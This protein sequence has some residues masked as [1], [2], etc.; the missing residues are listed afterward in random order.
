MAGAPEHFD[1]VVVGTGFGGSVTAQRLAEADRRVLV[2][3]RGN[4]VAS[5]EPVIVRDER[6]AWIGPSLASSTGADGQTV[7]A[8]YPV[9]VAPGDA[10]CG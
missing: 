3:E 1:C 4:T 5:M 6:P 10:R 2:L 7:W 9:C 8:V